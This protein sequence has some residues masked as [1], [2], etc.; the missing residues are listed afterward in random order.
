M[1]RPF[2][3]NHGGQDPRMER[4]ME[5]DIETEDGAGAGG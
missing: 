1:G 3:P 4:K 2:L 5:D